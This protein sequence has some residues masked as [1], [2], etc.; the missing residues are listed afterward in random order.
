[1]NTLHV[2]VGLASNSDAAFTSAVVALVVAM[3][4]LS[5]ELADVRSRHARAES[6]GSAGKHAG[7]DG[8]HRRSAADDGGLVSA[9]SG[10]QAAPGS[11]GIVLAAP[12]R[13]FSE[14]VGRA[15]L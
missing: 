15:G 1:M 4:L 14:R 11:P 6:P 9:G 2:H 7:P 3:L 13:P 12:R 8:Q 5:V 10:R